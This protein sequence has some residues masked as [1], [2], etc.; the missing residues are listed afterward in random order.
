MI[1]SQITGRPMIVEAPQTIFQAQ[2]GQNIA[3]PIVATGQQGIYINPQ[4]IQQTQTSTQP[5]TKD[6]HH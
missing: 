6:E 3:I 2:N 1:R 5:T 4:A